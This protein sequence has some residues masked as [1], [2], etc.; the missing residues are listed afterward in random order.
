MAFAANKFAMPQDPFHPSMGPFCLFSGST[1]V[2][3]QFSPPNPQEPLQL[4]ANWQTKAKLPGGTEQGFPHL[5]M[6]QLTN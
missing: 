6:K 1:S 5:Q 2:Q 4:T 3:P